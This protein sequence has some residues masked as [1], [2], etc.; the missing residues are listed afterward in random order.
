MV[1]A[2]LF[3]ISLLLLTGEAD[4]TLAT[5]VVKL[6]GLVL[7]ALVAKSWRED[8]SSSNFLEEDCHNVRK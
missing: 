2:L 6:V 1:R 7:L 3:V 4:G 5:I 8:K